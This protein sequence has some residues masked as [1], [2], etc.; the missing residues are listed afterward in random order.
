MSSRYIAINLPD[1]PNPHYAALLYAAWGSIVAAG[2]DEDAS[3]EHDDQISDIEIQGF[4]AEVTVR[5]SADD[6]LLPG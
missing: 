5:L 6:G 4:A 1:M 3:C 2:L